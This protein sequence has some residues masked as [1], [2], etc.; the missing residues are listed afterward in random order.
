MNVTE[1][2]KPT[3]AGLNV[4]TPAADTLLVKLSGEWKITEPLPATADV[5]KPLESAKGI[6]RV[7]FG[8]KDLGGWDR[9]SPSVK[10]L[11]RAPRQRSRLQKTGSL[12]GSGD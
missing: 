2:T 4:T 11:R 8:T 5:E 9:T 7:T 10:S 3:T 1:Q 12:K 6:R